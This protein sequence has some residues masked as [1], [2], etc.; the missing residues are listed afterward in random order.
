MARLTPLSW[1]CIGN[2]GTK[3]QEAPQKIFAFSFFVKDQSAIKTIN[4]TLKQ[5]WKTE[6]VTSHDVRIVRIKD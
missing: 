6:N 3:Y 2:S 4:P 5:F 1:T